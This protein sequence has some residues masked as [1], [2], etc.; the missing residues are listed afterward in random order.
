MDYP[1]KLLFFH[2]LYLF[3]FFFHNINASLYSSN[4]SKRYTQNMYFEKD[5]RK[6]SLNQYPFFKLKPYI[7]IWKKKKKNLHYTPK[8]KILP[9]SNQDQ[10]NLI[11][12]HTRQSN[13]DQLNQSTIQHPTSNRSV[14]I[15]PQ[16]DPKNKIKF[17]TKPRPIGEHCVTQKPP[18]TTAPPITT[19]P[20]ISNPNCSHH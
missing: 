19:H 17:K 9:T 1:N 11:Q 10:S 15:T 5:Y 4:Q 6:K 13:I 7:L 20:L 2:V 12:Y 18:T 8:T 14:Y 3:T 16:I